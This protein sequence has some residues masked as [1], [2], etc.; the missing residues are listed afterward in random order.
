[1]Q[2]QGACSHIIQ[3]LNASV[4]RISHLKIQNASHMQNQVRKR[5]KLLLKITQQQQHFHI[6]PRTH[7]AGFSSLLLRICYAMRAPHC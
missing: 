2:L 1:M 4:I 5:N 6:S 7:E 3:S